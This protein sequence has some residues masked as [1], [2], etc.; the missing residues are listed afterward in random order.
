[1]ASY[2][3]F[4][5]K[6]SA[7][8][9]SELNNYYLTHHKITGFH[10]FKKFTKF[11]VLNKFLD[12]IVQTCRRCLGYNYSFETNVQRLN[13]VIR[14]DRAPKVSAKVCIRSLT[15]ILMIVDR[16]L[17][18]KQIGPQPLRDLCTETNKVLLKKVR[19]NGGDAN[20]VAELL[21][22]YLE[23]NKFEKA[24]KLFESGV[25]PADCWEDILPKLPQ[26]LENPQS[27]LHSYLFTFSDHKLCFEKESG[28][29]QTALLDLLDSLNASTEDYKNN[30]IVFTYTVNKCLNFIASLTLSPDDAEFL[31]GKLADLQ[32]QAR[33]VLYHDD[34]KE[35]IASA[36]HTLLNNIASLYGQDPFDFA[37]K[38][39]FFLEAYDLLEQGIASSFSQKEANEYFS[40]LVA[41][42][43]YSCALLLLPAGVD[44][45]QHKA[46]LA[47]RLKQ[48]LLTAITNNSP[49]VATLIDAGLHEGIQVLAMQTAIERNN[50]PAVQKL[51]EKSVSLN[52]VD[53]KITSYLHLAA[54]R[55]HF[56]LMEWLSTKMNVRVSTK[57]GYTAY[58][59]IS[60]QDEFTK[61]PPVEQAFLLGKQ[62]RFI[63][64]LKAMS[65]PQRYIA[66]DGLRKKFP[67]THIDDLLYTINNGH[68]QNKKLVRVPD[69]EAAGFP[70]TKL[71]DLFN[72][73]NFV[74]PNSPYY[75]NPSEFIKTNETPQEKRGLILTSLQGM[76]HKIK[77]NIAFLGT[78]E[79]GAP[80]LDL[81]YSLIR[82]ALSNT[83]AIILQMPD[84][85]KKAE[86][87]RRVMTEYIHASFLCGGRLYSTACKQYA[88]ALTG[89]TAQVSSLEDDLTENLAAYRGT[90]LETLVPDGEHSVHDYN[91]L[92][93]KLGTEFGIPGAEMLND[94]R[95]V[96]MCNGFNTD[97]KRK[98]FLD[99]YTVEN[100]LYECVK[101]HVEQTEEARSK[102]LDWCRENMPANW[103]SDK[104]DPIRKGAKAFVTFEDQVKFLQQ[105]DIVMVK[106]QTIDEAINDER[107]GLYFAT[108]VVEDPEAMK[109]QIK[110][111]AIAYYLSKIGIFTSKL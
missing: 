32:T 61:R 51:H 89:N 1:M 82:R 72:L 110:P 74:D 96:Y 99:L 58:H 87:V 88:A 48:L 37:V 79:A 104:F 20:S 5:N 78:P 47:N 16:V 35:A 84:P 27:H 109:M 8:P 22:Y 69:Q 7:V 25:K 77:N 11:G 67:A 45:E 81:F 105:H 31:L 33:D 41:G 6:L 17:D 52:Y 24:E 75:L 63:T 13:A 95:E 3:A 36:R 23:A 111:Q 94:F 46:P 42:K 97:A 76:I 90:L 66:L 103:Q 108:E 80:T 64:L 106:N 100:I 55:G 12:R 14:A 29:D 59:H 98:E 70:I 18:K 56:E 101:Q 38:N 92:M 53:D 85:D 26:L 107:R 86:L 2:H 15:R 44:L 102:L 68:Y 10:L 43:E 4:F 9:K 60:D 39:N 34:L 91:T 30:P 40:Q 19:T 54:S 65:P 28:F 71:L 21:S 93:H 62:E 49:H 73:V 83:L 57:K 50:L